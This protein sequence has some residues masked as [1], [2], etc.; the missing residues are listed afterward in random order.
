MSRQEDFAMADNPAPVRVG[1]GGW[2]Y[3]PW[4]GT[5]YPKGLPHAKELE[6]ASRHVTSIEVN[7]TFYRLQTPKTF[8]A[9]AE[10]TPEGFVFSLKAPRYAVNRKELATA[11]PAVT[12]F[13]ESGLTELGKKLGIILWQLAP[14]KKLDLEDLEAFLALLPKEQDGVKLRHALEVRHASFVD[15]RLV[16]LLRRHEVAVVLED[17]A[18]H[19]MIADLTA[20]FF[21]ARLRRSVETEPAGYAPEALDLW[22]ERCRAW[23]AGREPERLRRITAEPAP[24]QGP[25][26]CFVYFINGAKVR[27]PAAAMALLERLGEA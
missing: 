10:A 21:Y 1:I 11:G 26:P 16:A 8:R 15:E 3:E 5:F 7:G 17:D 23:A 22:A 24:A 20:D 4:R 12:R 14:T 19:P 25:R 18:E 27:A 2:T 6:H 13:L 9:W